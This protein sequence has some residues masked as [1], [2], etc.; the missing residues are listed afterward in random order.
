MTFIASDLA[1]GDTLS[2]PD[3]NFGVRVITLTQ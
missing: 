3:L 1:A 2:D